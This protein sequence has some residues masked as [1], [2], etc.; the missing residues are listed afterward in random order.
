MSTAIV[1]AVSAVDGRQP[2][3]LP[4]LTDVYLWPGVVTRWRHHRRR[5]DDRATV[6]GRPLDTPRKLYY[7]ANEGRTGD[8]RRGIRERS[9]RGRP[10]THVAEAPDCAG[11]HGVNSRRPSTPD[12]R[13]PL[14][15]PT[16]RRGRSCVSHTGDNA[17]FQV[18]CGNSRS[19]PECGWPNA[20]AAVHRLLQAEQAERLGVGRK[21]KISVM[22]RIFDSRT[23]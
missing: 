10:K 8:F 14:V 12:A 4:P 11:P 3:S 18:C 21:S 19:R 6:G 20:P 17:G 9:G 15:P 7:A 1:R 23:T 2:S 16:S 22:A 5:H 13:L